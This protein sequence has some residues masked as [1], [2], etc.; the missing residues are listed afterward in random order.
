[1]YSR[2]STLEEAEELQS[3]LKRHILILVNI[4]LVT[5]TYLPYITGVSVSTDSIARYMVSRG[6][7]VTLVCPK[8]IVKGTVEPLEGLTIVDT[9]SI[10]FAIYN[11][12][13]IAIFPLGIPIIEKLIRREKFDIV[14][15]QEPFG[16]GISALILAK[17]H[18]L[19]VIGSLHFIPE[20]TVISKSLKYFLT[21]ILRKS[22]KLIYNHYD[23]VMTVS[24]FFA[25]NLRKYGVTK[26][27]FI[28]SNGTDVDKF[29]PGPSDLI[30]RKKLGIPESSV[31]F[32]YLGR[33]DGDKNVETLV[34]AMPFTDPNVRLLIV[35]KGQK[36]EILH[37]LADDLKV[38]PKI[39]WVDY[40]TNEEMTNYYHAADCFSIMSPFEGQSI[41]TLQ[42][43]ASGLPVIV[44]NAGAL[45]ELCI[46]G[47]NGFLVE[48][49]DAKTL[50]DRMNKLAG[51]KSLREKFGI[52]SRKI[53]LP[54][55]K[56]TALHKLEELYKSLIK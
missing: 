1:L 48:T 18:H 15:I 24:N 25:E 11:N 6:H 17:I 47:K 22:I 40:I 31:V 46:D 32:F 12:N 51:D 43:V 27:I 45:P 49:Y 29:H 33:L 19:P 16:T 4:L 28:I 56:P 8:P 50:A 37:K 38:T 44:A 34:R 23:S 10:P 3:S 42:A 26:P 9:P 14:H 39:I 55:H 35:G 41:V 54:H 5:E 7:K 30:M 2:A 36:K 53:S 13:A 52:E 21:P 20:Q